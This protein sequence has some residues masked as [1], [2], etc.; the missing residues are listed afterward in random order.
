MAPGAATK[1]A[2]SP[3]SG[4]SDLALHAKV[5]LYA[6][7]HLLADR[8]RFTTGA[9]WAAIALSEADRFVY[10]AAAGNGAPDVE[11]H[12]D[13]KA[14]KSSRSVAEGKSL[15]VNVIRDAKTAGFFQL[16]SGRQAFSEQDTNSV[17]RL[18]E[19]VGTALDHLDGAQHSHRIITAAQSRP[20]PEG[21]VL[22]HAPDVA[23]SRIDS[24]TDGPGKSDAVVSLQSCQSCGFPVSRGRTICMDCEERGAK[25]SLELLGDDKRESR[26]SAHGYTIATV[27]I[28]A[29]AAAL[30]YWLR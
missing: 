20:K 13:F 10:R 14:L 30:Y 11:T 8:A 22:W 18:A 5:E 28:S 1:L 15:L 17:V 29:V 23:A 7:L 9:D 21:S 12:A 4:F 3:A 19:M 24:Q 6:C 2:P 16:V 27:L 26:I 25:P